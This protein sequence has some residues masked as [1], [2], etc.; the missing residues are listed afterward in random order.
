MH[1]LWYNDTGKGLSMANKYTDQ[2]L[3]DQL[4]SHGWKLVTENDKTAT[5]GTLEEMA[6]T[7]HQRQAEGHAPGVIAKIETAVE[8]DMLQ[9]EKLW[10]QLGLPV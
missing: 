5:T 3:A 2:E 10:L 7:T 9:I 8:L 4:K 1:P 6:R